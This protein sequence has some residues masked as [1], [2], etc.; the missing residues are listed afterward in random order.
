M[1]NEGFVLLTGRSDCI[2]IDGHDGAVMEGQADVSRVVV[3]VSGHHCR[4]NA[5]RVM[6]G[7]ALNGRGGEGETGTFEHVLEPSFRGR[8]VSAGAH[9]S[10]AP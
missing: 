6:H 1:V 9:E 7:H 8:G 3:P 5:F 10:V 2:E 4:I